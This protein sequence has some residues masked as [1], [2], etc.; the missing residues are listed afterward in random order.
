MSKSRQEL[1]RLIETLSRSEKGYIKKFAYKEDGKQSAALA[2]L[3]DV[4]KA[5]KKGASDTELD[6]KLKEKYGGKLSG[7]KHNLLELLLETLLEYER[8]KQIHYQIVGLFSKALLL[9]NRGLLKLSGK[10]FKKAMEK[11][12]END[13]LE[14]ELMA[15]RELINISSSSFPHNESKETVPPLMRR[16]EVLLREINIFYP[17]F[18]GFFNIFELN[19]QIGVSR[20]DE[21]VEEIK[22]LAENLPTQAADCIESSKVRKSIYHFYYAHNFML[23]EEEKALHY[24]I[25]LSEERELNV[26][27]T[28]ANIKYFANGYFQII[29]SGIRVENRAITDQY[30]QKLALLPTKN[31]V[32]EKSLFYDLMYCRILNHHTFGE[33]PKNRNYIA[34]FEDRLKK[35]QTEL[36]DHTQIGT[37]SVIVKHFFVTQQYDECLKWIDFQLQHTKP[38]QQ[39]PT[40]TGHRIIELIVHQQLGHVELLPHLVRNLYRQLLKKDRMFGG[41][42]IILSLLRQ[43][44]NLIDRNRIKQCYQQHLE[45]LEEMYEKDKPTRIFM[46]SFNLIAW[47]RS[48]VNGTSFAEELQGFVYS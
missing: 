37:V 38:D 39:I 16:Q 46:D 5:L 8:A 11:A 18:Q 3:E 29:Q 20:S 45:E 30:L 1:Y 24:A 44:V 35:E 9:K 48:R 26:P 19:K 36:L 14:L 22:T 15:C 33:Y 13:E 42:R 4:L 23:A 43:R 2:L 40:R 28:E 12:K 6:A 47:L 17:Y 25:K 31:P 27:F 7:L 32:T 10:Q 21:E 34:Q 41:E